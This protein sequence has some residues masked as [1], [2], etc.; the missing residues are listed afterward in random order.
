MS[1]MKSSDCIVLDDDFGGYP[2]EHFCTSPRYDGYLD[3]V[4][5]P[6]GMIKDRLEKMSLDIVN[7]YE[8]SNAK[9]ITLMCVLKGGFKFLAD[10][11]DG[12]ERTVRARG[13]VMP[14]SVEFVRV[15]SYVNDASTHEPLL[16]G[17]ED[18][19]E[20]RNKDILI[21]EDIVDTGKTITKLLNYLKSLSTR[22]VKVASLLVKRTPDGIG[23]RPEF[24]GF[25][26][27]NRFV[28]GYAL[29][30]NEHFRD[31]HHICVIN[32]MG[33]QKFSVPSASKSH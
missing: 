20:Y 27:P 15:K 21:V 17:M 10:L 29:D 33:K 4:L 1:E 2:V 30:Y 24:I 8:A 22:S 28:V 9:S 25:E 18:P 12:L 23:Y 14:M 7:A 3:Y 16:S 32:K 31:L 26:V 5:I 19:T 6:N 11:V 13:T